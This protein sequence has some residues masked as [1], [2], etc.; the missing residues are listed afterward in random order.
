MRAPSSPA[1]P[2]RR[3]YLCP[4]M[5]SRFPH[6]EVTRVVKAMRDACWLERM[7]GRAET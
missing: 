7:N 3:V 2:D 6:G 4:A 5:T 1:I